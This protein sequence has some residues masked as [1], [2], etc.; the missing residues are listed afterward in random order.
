VH[1]S[2]VESNLNTKAII[3]DKLSSLHILF[4]EIGDYSQMIP[5]VHFNLKGGRVIGLVYATITP[6]TNYDQNLVSG[7][8]GNADAVDIAPGKYQVTLNEP[9]Y[10]VIAVDPPLP[11]A[12]APGQ[13]LNEDFLLASNTVNSLIV[14]VKDSQTGSVLPNAS[15]R[16]HNSS[17]FDITQVTGQEG[18]VFFP[19]NTDPV[20]VLNSGS[21]TL[22]VSEPNHQTVSQSINISNLIQKNISLVP[23]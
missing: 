3:I 14:N 16:L 18:R 4:H 10:T 21:Y 9:G 6:V 7:S 8:E 11:I 20:T 22:D 2:V 5:N 12:L 13:D 1:A 15:V 17:G 23:N 19:P